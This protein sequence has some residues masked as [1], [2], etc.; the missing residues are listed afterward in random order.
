MSTLLSSRTLLVRVAVALAACVVLVACG[1]DDAANAGAA[2]AADTPPAVADAGPAED[3]SPDVAI[4]ALDSGPPVEVALGDVPFKGMSGFGP[5]EKDMANGADAPGDGKPLM[6][7]GVTYAKGLGVHA[8]S[9]LTFDLGRKYK[10]FYAEVGVDDEIGDFGSVQ[11]IVYVDDVLAFDSGVMTGKMAAQK[12]DISV[13]FT[14]VLKL[15]VTNG[16]DDTSYDHADWAA[17]RLL[18]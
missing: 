2:G 3:A 8:P 9:E 15:V 11:F 10:R 1:G 17:A 4:P 13:G 5:V 18:K 16:G 14:Q 6:I 12:I 7:G